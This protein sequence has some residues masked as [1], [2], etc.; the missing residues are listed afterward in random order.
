[1]IVITNRNKWFSTFVCNNWYVLSL[2]NLVHSSRTKI[3]GNRS[4]GQEDRRL[5]Y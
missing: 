4:Q 3:G 5:R 1:M 2:E